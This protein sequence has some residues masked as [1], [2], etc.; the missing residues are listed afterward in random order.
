ME[1]M[2]QEILELSRENNRLLRSM[3]R[4]AVWGGIIK[5][6]LYIALFIGLPIWL[7]ATYFSPIMN[8][9]LE[10]Y[11]AVG[12]AG[13]EAELQINGLKETLERFKTFLPQ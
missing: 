2:L 13:N 5:F 8:Q 9:M 7:Y 6:V 3:Q 10:V 12:G 4:R 11:S 1:S